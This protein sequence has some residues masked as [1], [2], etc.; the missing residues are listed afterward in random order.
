MPPQVT[1]AAVVNRPDFRR[2]S[3]PGGGIM[4]ARAIARHY[5]ML[6]GEGELDG[7]RILSVE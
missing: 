6:A 5:A 4:N 7:T 2:A 1:S 3:I